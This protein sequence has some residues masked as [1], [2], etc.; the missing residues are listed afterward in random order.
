[1]SIKG[2]TPGFKNIQH[3][4]ET[5]KAKNPNGNDEYQRYQ[6]RKDFILQLQELS[7]ARSKA[8]EDPSAG[9]IDFLNIYRSL[10]DNMKLKV[11]NIF[12]SN[13]SKS[14][15]Q[16]NIRL[17]LHDIMPKILDEKYKSMESLMLR[18]TQL[19]QELASENVNEYD[20]ERIN[21]EIE[22]IQKKIDEDVIL[23]Y[24]LSE[25]K[26]EQD[27][28]NIM[29]N[30][31]YGASSTE[32]KGSKK[33]LLSRIF[34]RNPKP[35]A[36]P[37]LDA[38]GNPIPAPEKKGFFSRFT[39]KNKTGDENAEPAVDATG[40]SIATPEKKSF[41]SRFTKKNKT[42]DENAEPAEP[43]VDAAGNPIPAPEKKG[44][45]SRFTK[46]NKTG[47]ENAE[48]AEPAVDATGN[49]IAT[50]EKKSFFRN[51]F[52]SKPKQED[53][54]NLQNV[55]PPGPILGPISAPPSRAPPPLPPP[56][57]RERGMTQAGGNKTRK[58]RHYIHDIKENRKELF[59]K[60]M[61][62]INSI[63]K[64]K[65]GRHV[66]N[67]TQNKNKYKNM[68]KRFITSVKK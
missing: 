37:D 16:N 64:F 23:L 6:A 53:A 14:L 13:E 59:N 32:Q 61:E 22:E 62:I 65:Y 49:S 51:P 50:P 34:K 39:K 8:L 27:L 19:E 3:Y 5:I 28:T 52:K 46:K 31:P 60:E 21:K 2:N 36:P 20:D 9:A 56:R 38:A 12:T 11:A 15:T 30:N 66:M 42:G 55:V 54:N 1:M 35:D 18:K 4:Y 67:G 45:F 26:S 40:N 43:A 63:R 47:D 33:S 7:N 29:G 25:V 68:K 24:K 41:F 10:I 57:V 58:Y 48:P 44:F 17:S